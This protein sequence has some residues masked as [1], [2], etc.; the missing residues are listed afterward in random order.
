MVV[1]G[2]EGARWSRQSCV[3]DQIVSR[4]PSRGQGLVARVLLYIANIADKL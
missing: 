3:S 4:L 2:V 1:D